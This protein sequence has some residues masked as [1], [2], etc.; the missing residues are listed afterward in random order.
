MPLL[1]A[2]RRTWAIFV[3]V[4]LLLPTVGLVAPDLP[5]PLRTMVAP[6]ARW[7]VRATER[8][9]PYINQTFG[10]RGAVLA[11]HNAYGRALGQTGTDKVLEGKDGALFFKEDMALEQSLGQVRRAAAITGIAEVAER[12]DAMVRETGG[13]FAMV[14]PPNGATVNFELLPDATQR[15][16]SPPTEYDLLGAE[17]ARRHIPFVDLRPIL[18]K[19]KADG[20]VQY[21]IDTHWN[22]RG[23]LIGFNA[24]MAAVGRPDLEIDPAEA[25][26]PKVAK[27]TGDLVRLSGRAKADKPDVDY[28]AKGPFVVPADLTPVDGLL[29]PPESARDPFPSQVFATG[30]GGPRILVIGDS[31]TQHFWTGLLAARA[32]VFGWMH[33]RYCK[34]DM[35]AVRR[36]RPDILLYVPA[37]RS[38]PC[39]R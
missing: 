17:M 7:W 3:F 32:S 22:R 16:L 36:F 18:A 8:L 11:A 2:Y 26:G 4:V 20:P 24:A 12:L 38:L 5:A 35:E 34:F 25:L 30:H 31:N 19:A 6:E 13:R 9:D 14:V 15:F 21:R 23:A 27:T 28:E 37:E 1:M 10:F 39:R 29:P 33:H